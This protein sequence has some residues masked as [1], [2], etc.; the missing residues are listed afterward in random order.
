VQYEIFRNNIDRIGAAEVNDAPV[1]VSDIFYLVVS[2]KLINCSFQI[3]LLFL[4]PVTTEFCSA[5]F[6]VKIVNIH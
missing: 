5:S 1:Q 2:S 3:L 6:V 4:D